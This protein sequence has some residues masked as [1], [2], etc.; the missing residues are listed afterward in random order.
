VFFALFVIKI[1]A[2]TSMRVIP[3][4]NTALSYLSNSSDGT[5]SNNQA[6]SATQKTS[7]ASAASKNTSK[8]A[9]DTKSTTNDKGSTKNRETYGLDTIA[10]MSNDEYAAF[11]RATTDMSP[12]EKMRA[13]QSLHLVAKSYQQ[14]QNMVSGA[15]LVDYMNG[16]TDFFS[17][18]QNALEQGIQVLRQMDNGDSKAMSNFLTRYKGALSSNGLNLTA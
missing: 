6:D 9:Q 14:A 12:T 1:E 8:E 13:A 5:T 15:G 17:Q 18:N 11:E 10:N 7:Q 4:N 16:K 3:D 2:K